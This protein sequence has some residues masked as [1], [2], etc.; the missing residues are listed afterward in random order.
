MSSDTSDTVKRMLVTLKKLGTTD[1]SY[2]MGSSNRI[3]NC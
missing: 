3:L 1:R 2:N